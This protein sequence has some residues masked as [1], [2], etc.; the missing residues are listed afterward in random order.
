MTLKCEALEGRLRS[1]CCGL[2]EVDHKG[3]HLYHDRR[4]LWAKEVQVLHMS[5]LD[6]L[7]GVEIWSTL[8][9]LTPDF[10]PNEGLMSSCLLLTKLQPFGSRAYFSM[11]YCLDYCR[12]REQSTGEIQNEFL[13][14]LERTT[15]IRSDMYSDDSEVDKDA[16][17][18]QYKA[19][20]DPGF[21]HPRIFLLAVAKAGLVRHLQSLIEYDSPGILS[22]LDPPSFLPRVI[23]SFGIKRSSAG[24]EWQVGDLA[25][26]YAEITILLLSEMAGSGDL[27]YT[28]ICHIW[29]IALESIR[30]ILKVNSE[31]SR[32]QTQFNNIM[33]FLSIL[34]AFVTIKPKLNT[35]VEYPNTIW[36]TDVSSLSLLLEGHLYKF[37]RS[38]S[39]D[40][41]PL[42]IKVQ[43]LLKHLDERKSTTHAEKINSYR[44]TV[45]YSLSLG[46]ETTRKSGFHSAADEQ[47]FT[48]FES[49]SYEQK[50]AEAGSIEGLFELD[51]TPIATIRSPAR[52]PTIDI[53]SQQVHD[54][55]TPSASRLTNATYIPS[56]TN[57]FQ[58]NSVRMYAQEDTTPPHL[59]LVPED[60]PSSA[61]L[62]SK[63]E[64][65]EISKGDTISS[66][67]KD[68][69]TEAGKHKR[70]GRLSRLF[71][72]K[73]HG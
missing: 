54:E 33:A 41:E 27:Y 61:A 70:S 5:V 28:G 34:E 65:T 38:N 51:A 56:V 53:M 16:L 25:K 48:T 57:D 40:S 67:R 12:I 32:D 29:Q 49:S 11:V 45:P 4:N 72:L 50:I 7:Y 9:S 1:R 20:S 58:E 30:N 24:I 55:N 64:A 59:Q 14:E 47:Q 6:F 13:Y 68:Q 17:Y 43:L 22:Q 39:H 8:R 69:D 10:D 66:S 71:G 26:E 21:P 44:G 62:P 52:E 63:P 60:T 2:I 23:Q 46:R 35:I 36:S 15:L 73:K 3:D 19:P 18:D 37:T 42:R 31:W